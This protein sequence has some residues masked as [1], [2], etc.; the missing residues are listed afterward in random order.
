LT[1]IVGI[2]VNSEVTSQ[3][4]VFAVVR[5]VTVIQQPTIMEYPPFQLGKP[6]FDQVNILTLCYFTLLNLKQHEQC[7]FN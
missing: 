7:V 6:R 2:N 5:F 3:C 1:H 4:E